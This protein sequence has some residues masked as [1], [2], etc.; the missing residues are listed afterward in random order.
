MTLTIELAGLEL[1]D[2]HGVDEDERRRGQT[3]VF[4][5]W[6]D[7]PDDAARSDRIEDAVDYREVAKAVREV[8]EGRPRR[9]LET[10]ATAIADELI[11][12]FPVERVRVR[13]RKPHVD[14]DAGPLEYSAVTV[15][16]LRE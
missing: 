15:E 11:A 7:V 6:L 3:F 13:V 4:D 10:V 16:R 9:L 2:H 1:Y 5:L 8:S 14:L 12:R